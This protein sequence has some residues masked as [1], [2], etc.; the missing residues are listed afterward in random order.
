MNIQSEIEYF[1][2]LGSIDKARFVIR[3]IAEVLEEV[4]LGAGQDGEVARSRFSAE[5]CQRLAR[6]GYQILS[7]DAARPSDEVVI[8]MLLGARADKSAD[9]IVQNAYRRV[10]TSFEGFDTT[11]LLNTH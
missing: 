5:L 7:E 1:S 3:L 6:F 10:L 9:R 11:V 4:K 8:R 2:D